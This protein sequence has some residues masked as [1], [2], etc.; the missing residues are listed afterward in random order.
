MARSSRLVFIP[1]V[2]LALLAA[3]PAL[4]Q[5]EQ[6]AA[7]PV[8]VSGDWIMTVQSDQG[9]MD[10]NLMFKQEG[11]EI[12][13]TLD[14]PMGMIE[15]AGEIDEEDNLAFWASIEIPDGSGYFDLYFSGTVAENKTI[16][17]TMDGGGGQ[18]TA[19]FTAKRKEKQ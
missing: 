8:G 18:F 5:E 3:M 19:D 14:G 16:A 17:G 13:G 12:T 6:E 10:M 9:A 2:A 4:A 15:I 1:F 11:N 7:P